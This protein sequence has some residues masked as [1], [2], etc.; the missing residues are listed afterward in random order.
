MT[1]PDL[2]VER[3]DEVAIVSLNRP[4]KHNALSLDLLRQ[5]ASTVRYLGEDASL[6]VVILRGNDGCFSTGMD[7]DDLAAVTRVADTQRALG[8]FRDA[9]GPVLRGEQVGRDADR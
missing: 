2:L 7:L 6:R 4:Q 9:L 1:D 3:R 8:V 5:L